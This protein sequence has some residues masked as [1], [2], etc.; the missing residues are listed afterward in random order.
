MKANRE[1]DELLCSFIDGE[2]PLRQQTEVQRLAARDPEVAERLRQLQNCKNLVSALPRAEAPEHM[3]EQIKVSLER[4]TLLEERPA[5]IGTR[6]GARHLKVRRFLAAA[7]MIALLGGL[8][9]VIYQIVAPVSPPGSASMVASDDGPVVTTPTDATVAT[10][11]FSGTLE[12]STASFAQADA[13]VKAVIEENGLADLTESEMLNGM[14]VYHI[15]ASRAGVHRLVAD[16]DDIW[17]NSDSATLLVNTERFADP[18]VIEDVTQQQAARIIDQDSAQA[19]VEMAQE[20]AVFN[21]FAGGT[22]GR[23]VLPAA[24]DGLDVAVPMP[25]I[26]R[27]RMA[28]NDP[29]SKVI[30]VPPEG[31]V[32][33]SLTIVLLN[34]Q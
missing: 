3:L 12:L 1:T 7:A 34:T 8:G 5:L 21:L 19:S 26:P 30:P 28:S 2:L 25:G 17:Q 23:E 29:A 32:K 18:V 6:A 33:A 4:K 10:T 15:E 11:G 14:R 31:T 27:P 16:L 13:I 22:P 24:G 9:A 20:I